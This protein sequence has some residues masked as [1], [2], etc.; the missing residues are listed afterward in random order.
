MPSKAM[1]LFHSPLRAL[2]ASLLICLFATEAVSQSVMGVATHQGFHFV[3]HDWEVACDNTRTFR[4]AGYQSVQVQ[5]ML[6]DTE[7]VDGEGTPV[8]S[9][10]A[11]VA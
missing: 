3:H 9:R 8:S 4:A 7:M 2:A 11:P 5:L 1:Q 6:G 10:P